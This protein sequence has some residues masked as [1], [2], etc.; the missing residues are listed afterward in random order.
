VCDKKAKPGGTVHHRAH[1]TKKSVAVSGITL[2]RSLLCWGG[3]VSG[4][5]VGEDEGVG[6]CQKKGIDKVKVV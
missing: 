5:M 4:V 2:L 6:F 3:L 1:S